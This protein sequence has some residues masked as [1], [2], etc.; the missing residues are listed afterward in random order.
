MS[1]LNL[2]FLYVIHSGFGQ[3][4]FNLEN[5]ALAGFGR[6]TY[7]ASILENGNCIYVGPGQLPLTETGYNRQP[8]KTA[9]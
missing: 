8:L 2:C 3:R 1:S 6:G 5:P 4:I 7:T 9:F